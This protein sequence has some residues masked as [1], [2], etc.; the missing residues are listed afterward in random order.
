MQVHVL[1]YDAFVTVAGLGNPAG[2]VLDAQGLSDD[3]MQQIAAAMGF[4]ETAFVLPSDR[5]DLRIRYWTPGHEVNL[6]GHATI[7][8]V[9]APCAHLCDAFNRAR[10]N[11]STHRFPT[12]TSTILIVYT[13]Y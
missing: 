13:V 10:V 9:W 8:T 4:N 11:P 5:A 3:A 6:C 2:V 12:P 1:H 7:A